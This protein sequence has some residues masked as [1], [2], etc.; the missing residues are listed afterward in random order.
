MSQPF[1]GRH[2]G[3]LHFE[4]SMA[5]ARMPGLVNEPN[6]GEDEKDPIR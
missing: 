6:E 3:P 5:G 1:V 4:P 2:G